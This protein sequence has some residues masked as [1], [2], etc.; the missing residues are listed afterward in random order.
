[1]FWNLLLPQN[2]FISVLESKKPDKYTYKFKFHQNVDIFTYFFIIWTSDN[3]IVG[4]KYK[5]S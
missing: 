2:H 4:L 5:R 1:M 3:S